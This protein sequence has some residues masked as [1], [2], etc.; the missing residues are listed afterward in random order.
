MAVYEFVGA[1][2]VSGSTTNLVSFTSIS[3][4]DDWKTFQLFG[5]LS[6]QDT[7]AATTQS[8]YIQLNSTSGNYYVGGFVSSGSALSSGVWRMGGY[9]QTSFDAQSSIQANQHW[10]DTG[11]DWVNGRGTTSWTFPMAGA[12]TRKVAGGLTMSGAPRNTSAGG[13]DSSTGASD[14]TDALTTVNVKCGYTQ[15]FG[16]GSHF[17]LYAIKDTNA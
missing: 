14:N 16:D 15:Y 3:T 6:L 2:T 12:A 4:S 10:T 8:L 1:G 5:S 9:S 17:E 13:F 11:G 7:S